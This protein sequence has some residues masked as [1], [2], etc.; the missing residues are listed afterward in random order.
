MNGATGI[1]LAEEAYTLHKTQAS[2]GMSVT[3]T[4][5]K[6]D[7]RVFGLAFTTVGEDVR[8]D[9]FLENIYDAPGSY[10]A[11]ANNV[12]ATPAPTEVP[13]YMA[14]MPALNAKGFLDEG[15][16]IYSSED[17]GLWIYVSQ[18]S[19]VIIQRKYDATQPLTW[20]EADLYGDLDAGEMLRTVQNDPEKMGKVRVDVMVLDLIMPQM[21]GFALM[22]E[23][24]RQQLANPPQIIVVSA[25][26]RDDFIMRAVQLGARF[27]M[28]K[29]FD[30]ASLAARIR[31]SCG[32]GVVPLGTTLNAS[33][34][35]LS[36]DE[37]LA[38][39]FLTIGI[40]AHIKGYQFLR[41][42][43]KMVVDNPDMINRITKELYPSIGKCYNTSA[44]KVERAIRH[45]IEVAWSRGRIDTLNKAFGCRVATKEDKPTNGE[46]IAMLADKLSLEQRSAS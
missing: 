32:Q 17:E 5:T 4:G 7:N 22:E 15:E 30:M 19:K 9:D 31:E 41:T 20:F 29:P 37:K 14:H 40:P 43:V 44:S 28:V 34:R 33:A 25:L 13:A 2:S 10:D 3:E 42:A 35:S 26:G 36:I 46:F 21:D 16:Y 38:S 1:E 23:V 11:A 18:T 45:A 6:Y 39:L 12:E 24:R 8:K 27:Y